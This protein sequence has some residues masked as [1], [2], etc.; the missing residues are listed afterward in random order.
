MSGNA[1]C[2]DE[3]QYGGTCADGHGYP[4]FDPNVQSTLIRQMN[5][6]Y[7]NH[8]SRTCSQE[9][10]GCNGLD[11]NGTVVPASLYLTSKPSWWCNESPW[12]PIGPDVTGFHAKIPAQIALEGGAC[13]HGDA[14]RS[15]PA[16]PIGLSIR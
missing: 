15:P 3:I 6:D 4:G 12:P 7:F 13:T 10:E 8:V 14:D 11:P 9:P 16:A 5:Y 1:S 2:I